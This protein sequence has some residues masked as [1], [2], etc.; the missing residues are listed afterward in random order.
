MTTL[1]KDYYRGQYNF[2]KREL[3][4]KFDMF[5]LN[6]IQKQSIRESV[7]RMIEEQRK[8]YNAP[9]AEPVTKEAT[10]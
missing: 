1:T 8:E 4:K 9:E 6:N 2:A 3:E 10:K 5:D 7:D